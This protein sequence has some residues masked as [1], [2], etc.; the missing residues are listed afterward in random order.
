MKINVVSLK[1]KLCRSLNVVFRMN[2]VGGHKTTRANLI[3]MN[4][5]FTTHER[6][7]KYT[8]GNLNLY[9][10]KKNDNAMA[11]NKAD[12]NKHI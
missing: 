1:L 6:Q 11:N 4:S 10:E 7:V 8:E 12:Q 9:L 5:K 3:W 2:T